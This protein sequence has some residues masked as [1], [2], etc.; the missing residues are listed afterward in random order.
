MP[1]QP[2]QPNEFLRRGWRTETQ[3]NYVLFDALPIRNVQTSLKSL[4]ANILGPKDPA[5]G[6]RYT[7]VFKFFIKSFY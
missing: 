2:K 7:I 4:R 3:T 6:P 5:P 1:A